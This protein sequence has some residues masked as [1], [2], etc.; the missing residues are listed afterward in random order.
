MCLP[1]KAAHVVIQFAIYCFLRR[2]K[3]NEQTPQRMF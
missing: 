1:V 3:Q 2:G